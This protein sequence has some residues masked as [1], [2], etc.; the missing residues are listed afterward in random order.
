MNLEDF[1]E[2]TI[3]YIYKVIDYFKNIQFS[4][5]AG[6]WKWM[7]V[8]GVL[9]DTPE[10]EYYVLPMRKAFDVQMCPVGKGL[11]YIFGV[12]F[13]WE[14]ENLKPWVYHNAHLR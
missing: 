12:V 8:N 5:E 1:D 3:K 6:D 9:L 14:G 11:C 7:R 2:P 13:E 4:P 10:Y